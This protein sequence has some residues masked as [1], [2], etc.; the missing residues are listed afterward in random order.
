MWMRAMEMWIGDK[1]SSPAPRRTTVLV[2]P[3]WG[4]SSYT[5]WQSVWQRD[6]DDC[7]RAEIGQW[8]APEPALWVARLDAHVRKYRPSVIVAHS[9]GCIATSLW[10][11]H[12]PGPRS[13]TG[14][15]LVAPCDP[16]ADRSGLLRGF[17]LPRNAL[18]LRS[19]LI[20]STN[21]PYASIERSRALAQRWGSTFISA[22]AAGHLNAASALGRWPYG[23]ALL[24]TLLFPTSDQD[25]AACG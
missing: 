1:R 7:V 17:P 18:P 3:G 16:D 23:Q 5:H 21:D 14:A 6:R 22:G 2:V 24:N 11:A 15:L 9:L 4:N 19:I 13:V 8:H 20:A 12:G 10:A 25:C